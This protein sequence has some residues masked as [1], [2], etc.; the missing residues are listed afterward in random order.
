MNEPAIAAEGLTGKIARLVQERGWNQDG[1]ARLAGVSRLTVRAIFEDSSRRL[2]NST[3]AKCARALGLSVHDLCELPLEELLRRS[4]PIPATKRI[5][6]EATQPELLAWMRSNAARAERLT[7]E[8][9]DELLSLQ[10]TGGPLTAQGV[11]CFVDLIERKRRIMEKMAVIAGTEYID[12]L[13]Q[14]V[15]VLLD[16]IQPYRDRK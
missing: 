3:L 4:G 11:E 1:F 13:E 9:W 6:E 8:E 12:A 2:H 5:Y 15:D 7:A 14:F 16:K 10:G